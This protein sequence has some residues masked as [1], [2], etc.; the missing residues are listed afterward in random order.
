MK[1]SWKRKQNN[2]KLKTV[3]NSQKH[4]VLLSSVSLKIANYTIQLE[5]QSLGHQSGTDTSSVNVVSS[6]DLTVN[7]CLA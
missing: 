6:E 7:T 1:V 4:A 5:F 2:H 3:T